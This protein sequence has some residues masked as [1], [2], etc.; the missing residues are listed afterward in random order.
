LLPNFYLQFF[1]EG[2]ADFFM[3]RVYLAVG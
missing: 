2:L 1:L 3:D